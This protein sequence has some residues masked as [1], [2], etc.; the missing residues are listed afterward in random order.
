MESKPNICDFQNKSRIR[1]T[2]RRL[3]GVSIHRLEQGRKKPT[4]ILVSEMISYQ[5]RRVYQELDVIEAFYGVN[6]PNT[7][8]TLL[9]GMNLLERS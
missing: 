2:G 6:V 1:E 7:E 3:S 8:K 4:P 9:V 5:S